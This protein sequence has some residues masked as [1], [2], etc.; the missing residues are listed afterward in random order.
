MITLIAARSKNGVIGNKGLIPW[1]C[2][3]ELRFF[4]RT[5][6]NS[7]VIMGRNTWESL[8]QKYRPLPSRVNIIVSAVMFEQ[9]I[10]VVDKAI[11]AGSIDHALEI[12]DECCHDR[13]IFVI[14]GGSLYS[15]FLERDLIDRMIIST[16]NQECKGDI[17]FPPYN[18]NDWLVSEWV[19]HN[20]FETTYLERKRGRDD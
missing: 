3:D 16:I 5:T 17:F 14:G 12:A 13:N 10:R 4:A 15:Q 18:E 20:G 8:P 1:H 11:I 6:R 9:E 19:M 7:I 2:P